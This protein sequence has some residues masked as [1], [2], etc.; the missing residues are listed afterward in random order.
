M[1]HRWVLD[2][3]RTMTHHRAWAVLLF[4]MM[5][6]SITLP[7]AVATHDLP[8]PDPP[9]VPHTIPAPD[10]PADPPGVG[11]DPGELAGGMGSC[12]ETV[13]FAFLDAITGLQ[14]LTWFSADEPYCEDQGDQ[15]RSTVQ[16]LEDQVM[17][18]APS[19]DP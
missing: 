2:A 6:L 18:M 4:L 7:S 3:V 19:L 9:G 15:L 11:A 12:A 10:L 14:P 1:P 8:G 16:G 5:S 13:L 17:G